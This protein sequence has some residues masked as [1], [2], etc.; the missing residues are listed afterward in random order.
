MLT[1][2]PAKLL[3]RRGPVSLGISACY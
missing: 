3:Y 1:L 2:R